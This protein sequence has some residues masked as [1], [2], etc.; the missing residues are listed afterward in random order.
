VT[1]RV[2]ER[3]IKRVPQILLAFL[4]VNFNALWIVLEQGKSIV[5]VRNTTEH[6]WADRLVVCPIFEKPN[7]LNAL[8]RSQAIALNEIS[9]CF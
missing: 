3:E 8:T 5:F 9:D 7:Q 6:N 1:S 4:D 2:P